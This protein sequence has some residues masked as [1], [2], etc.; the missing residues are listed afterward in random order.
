ML[1]HKKVK[2][3]RVFITGATGILGSQIL[4]LFLFQKNVEIV[5]LIRGKTLKICKDRSRV[6]INKMSKGKKV[7]AKV[8]VV[9]GDISK[10][11][12]GINE[13]IYNELCKS[14]NEIF[15]CAAL[16]DYYQPYRIARLVN[17]IGTKNV[18]MFAKNCQVLEKMNYISTVFIAGSLQGDFSENSFDLNQ[19]FNSSYEKSKFEAEMLVRKTFNKKFVTSIFRPSVIVGAYTD[20]GIGNFQLFYQYFRTLSLSLIKILP[21][22]PDSVFNIVPCDSA[23]KAICLLSKNS[24]ENETYH[25]ISP[26]NI[27]NFKLMKFVSKYIGYDEPKYINIEN[28]DFQKLTIFEKKLLGIYLPFLNI[29]TVFNARKTIRQLKEYGF[30]YPVVNNR[31]IARLIDYAINKKFIIK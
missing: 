26:Q 24:S 20:G 1:N 25:I 14:I 12:I 22:N 16:I 31:F 8:T 7:L 5:L 4:K 9:Q 28:F 27:S 6:F 23:A 10:F 2:I 11:N 13:R 17:V 29:K 3:K 21:V 30:R 18:L 15:H 19:T